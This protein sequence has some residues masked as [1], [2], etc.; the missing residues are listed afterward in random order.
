[1]R[2]PH[3]LVA[4]TTLDVSTDAVVRQLYRRGV[5]CTRLNTETYPFQ[6]QLTFRIGSARG[7]VLDLMRGEDDKPVQLDPTSIWFRRMRSPAR[8]DDM[9]PGIYDFCLRE[10]RA[11]L[12]GA[13]CAWPA[14]AMSRPENVWHAE[15]KLVQLR[16]AVKCG[17]DV[18]ETVVTNEPEA[19]RAAFRAFDGEMIAKP[20]R[21]GYV[22]HGDEQHAVYTN[23]IAEEHLVDLEDVRWS[24]AIYQRLVEKR[25]DV[26][27]TY[28][29]GTFFVA[30]ID[31]Q[32][33]LAAAV[34]WR[35]TNDPDLPHRESE[36]PRDVEMRAKTLMRELGLEFGA[37]DFVRTPD[38]Q[39]VFLEVNPNGQWLWIED[40]LGFRIS[41]AIAE[42]LAGEGA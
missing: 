1:M 14:K 7:A 38:D 15:H 5:R 29:G 40:R 30:E 3:V 6:S 13:L 26:R 37:L 25:C 32:T 41:A 2:E 19:V 33:D 28:V 34:D 36:L 22:D 21:S 35:R 4:S 39:Y 16:A 20:A 17:L 11:T 12:L 31:S 24:P 10:S 23:R 27:A 18:P 42:W 9:A 8:P